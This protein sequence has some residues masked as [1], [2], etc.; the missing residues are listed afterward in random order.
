M[1]PSKKKKIKVQIAEKKKTIVGLMS[2]NCQGGL[3]W[4]PMDKYNDHGFI[5]TREHDA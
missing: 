4:L 2:I 5:S 1:D 3:G